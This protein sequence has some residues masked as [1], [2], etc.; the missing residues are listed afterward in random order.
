MSDSDASDPFFDPSTPRRL[1]QHDFDAEYESTPPWDIGAPQP[2]FVALVEAGVLRGRVLDAGCG[3]GEHALLADSLGFDAT[4]IDFSPRAIELAREK[5]AARGLG[6][7]F[8]VG[9]ALDLSVLPGQFD[10]VFDCGLFH[11]FNDEQRVRYVESLRAATAPAGHVLVLCFSDRVPGA[12]GPR[13]ITEAELRSSF[14]GGWTVV[15]LTRVLMTTTFAP[16]G[17]DAWRAVFARTD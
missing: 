16:A 15:S 13:R 8:V 12:F 11:V 10:T 7:A 5:A 9:D 3:T 6:A 14:A 1:A 4:G 17:L 2:A